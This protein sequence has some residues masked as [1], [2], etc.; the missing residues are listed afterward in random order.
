GQSRG[1][2]LGSSQEKRRYMNCREPAQR[3]RLMK[4]RMPLRLHGTH[5]RGKHRAAR[6]RSRRPG[7]I[8]HPVVDKA[9]RRSVEMAFINQAYCVVANRDNLAR[10]RAL[11]RIRKQN[12]EQHRFI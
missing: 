2:R 12:T 11:W 6:L 9:L 7:T 10:S 4:Y 5:S 8:A 1:L 3:S